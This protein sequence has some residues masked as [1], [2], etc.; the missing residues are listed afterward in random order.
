VRGRARIARLLPF[1]AKP[2]WQRRDAECDREHAE[3]MHVVGSPLVA[4]P[5]AHLK[6]GADA[7][8]RPSADGSV[9]GQVA[10]RIEAPSPPRRREL[11]SPV[12][13]CVEDERM[14]VEPASAG[15][16]QH[17][18]GRRSGER[19]SIRLKPQRH[20]CCL[21]SC[22][23]S[24][25]EGEVE[26]GMLPSR[27]AEQRVDAP[28]AIDPDVNTGAI[29]NIEDGGYIRFGHPS[30]SSRTS[31]RGSP[32]LCAPVSTT[33]RKPARSNIDASPTNAKPLL[34]R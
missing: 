14:E 29:E 27:P 13:V 26:I 15:I 4:E 1:A 10:G 31:S 33:R 6:G 18:A 25:V 19:G 7:P 17:D 34:I 30:K 16:D 21:R 11:L 22:Q 23:R 28:A 20:E 5:E 24:A 8:H 12:S 32:A 2:R 9:C 3:V